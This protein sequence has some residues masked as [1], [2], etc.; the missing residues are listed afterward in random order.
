VS[1]LYTYFGGKLMLRLKDSKRTELLAA[2]E[3]AK[4]LRERLGI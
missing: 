4:E 2:K 1:E 3:R